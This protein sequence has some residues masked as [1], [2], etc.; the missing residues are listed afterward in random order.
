MTYDY[1]AAGRAGAGV[2]VV[3]GTAPADR[4]RR[5]EDLVC[6]LART[7]LERGLPMGEPGW[8]I[9]VMAF[10]VRFD[11]PRP[12]PGD[13]PSIDTIKAHLRSLIRARRLP[14]ARSW[15]EA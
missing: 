13:F 11:W 10:W 8:S 4:R 9:A 2:R 1:A 5:D 14:P 6:A 12:R 7:R 15:R 3:N